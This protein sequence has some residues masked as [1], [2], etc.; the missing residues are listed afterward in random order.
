MVKKYTKKEAV[1]IAI[2]SAKL[3]KKNFVGK[4]FLFIIID[5]KKKVYSFKTEFQASNFQH[6]TGLKSTNK[7]LSH[8]DFYNLCLKA[9]LKESDIEF[10]P[11]GTTHQKLSV[12][13]L[14]LK[15]QN[16]SVNMVGN[17]NNSYPLLYTE[18]LVGNTKWALGFIDVTG[19]GKFIPNTLLEGDVRNIV[20]EPYRVIATYVKE[21]SEL[22]FSNRI[23][24]ATNINFEE[25]KYPCDWNNLPRL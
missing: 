10:N 15:N 11:N 12:L 21:K 19:K 14:I 16:L 6:L 9:R 2:T 8:L 17:Y 5:K 24:L 7:K 4:E 3:Y 22:N 23:Y 18:K 13:S 20:N 1:S 25:L